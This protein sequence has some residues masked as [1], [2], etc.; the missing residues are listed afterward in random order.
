M[1]FDPNIRASDADRDKAVTL[2]REHLAAGRLTSDEFDERLEKALSARTLG[3][4]DQLM[5]DLPGIDMYR[6][7]DARLTRQP[8]QARSPRE[9]ARRRAEVWRA[10]WGSWFTC[11]LLCFVIWALTGRGYLW[12]LWI[13]GP[14]GVILLGRL[15]SGRHPHGRNLGPGSG[16]PGELPGPGDGPGQL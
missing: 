11:T 4:L 9:V 10:V 5:A 1:A 3:D 16:G 14:W 8:M 15:V 6:L 7:P 2:L 12:P 13:A